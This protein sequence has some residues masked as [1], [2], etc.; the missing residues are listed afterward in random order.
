MFKFNFTENNTELSKHVKIRHDEFNKD[1]K[2]SKECKKIE[3]NAERYK[4]IAKNNCST[5]VN[6][7]VSNDIEI[8]FLKNSSLTEN[9][10]NDLIPDLYEGGFQVWECTKDLADY[11][12]NE[13]SKEFEGKAICDLGCSAGLLGI[14][15]IINGASLVH[16]QDYVCLN[17]IIWNSTHNN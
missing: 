13:A 16:F 2:E 7:F 6:C 14:I 12:T 8:G 10:K 5:K 1:S 11:L 17:Q 4:E 15:G 9:T 3:I